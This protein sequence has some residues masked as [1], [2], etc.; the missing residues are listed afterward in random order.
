MRAAVKPQIQRFAGANCQAARQG[1]VISPHAT[2]TTAGP[3]Q[4]TNTLSAAD[5]IRT[6]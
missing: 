1:T 6:R 5:Q 3:A 4:L 2:T